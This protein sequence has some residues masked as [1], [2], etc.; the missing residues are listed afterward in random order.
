MPAK[1]IGLTGNIG[2]GKTTVC[3]IFETF[4]VPVYYADDQAKLFLDSPQ[5]ISEILSIF[6]NDCV[7]AD[8]TINRK[9]LAKK[10]FSDKNQLKKLN[11]II[12]PRV[13]EGFNQ[14]AVQYDGDA[15][16]IME[17]AILFET[18]HARRLHKNILVTAPEQ[19]RIQRVCERDGVT[20]GDVQKRMQ[21][22]M[23]EA[24]K[25]KM[26]D[27]VINNNGEMALLPQVEKIH[28]L[29]LESDF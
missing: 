13:K 16:V 7:G 10:V 4:G 22:Q 11:E 27:Y 9:M 21:H 19:L 23:P 28:K 17:A 18:G 20:P 8:G 12:H 6:G 1:Q 29:I 14:W 3:R 5:V 26:A 24:D 2:S 15:Y 25:E